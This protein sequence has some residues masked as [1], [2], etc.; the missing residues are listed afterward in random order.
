[1]RKLVTL[2]LLSLC[3]ILFVPN[4]F[5]QTCTPAGP[6]RVGP[7][8][9][10]FNFISNT[11]P[12]DDT[13]W[14]HAEQVVF[15]TGVTSCS[16]GPTTTSPTT[17]NAFAFP[18]YSGG[19]LYQ[20]IVIPTTDTRKYFSLSYFLDFDDPNNDSYWNRFFAYVIDQTTGTYLFQSSYNGSMPDLLCARRDSPT[21][22][23]PNTLAGHTIRVYFKGMT[24][25]SD[26]HIRVYG[27]ALW[28]WNY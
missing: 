2:S 15:V 20:D 14:A 17:T 18:Y 21:M 25:Y 7:A 27:V 22:Y 19:V 28:G 3:F 12:A 5:G 10:S 24:P 13:C 1:M 26:T 4:S 8:T 9:D 16:S 23:F 11:G 6:S